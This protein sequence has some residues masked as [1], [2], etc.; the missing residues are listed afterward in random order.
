VRRVKDR[1]VADEVT[2]VKID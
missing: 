2:R 1:V